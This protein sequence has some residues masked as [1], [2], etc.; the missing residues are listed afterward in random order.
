M[1][2]RGSF[3]RGYFGRIKRL[4][5]S[6]QNDMFCPRFLDITYS[7]YGFHPLP[8]E[9]L[10]ERKDDHGSEAEVPIP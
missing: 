2:F 1:S 4:V 10:C 7:F 9:V 3:L 6:S 5:L 8:E